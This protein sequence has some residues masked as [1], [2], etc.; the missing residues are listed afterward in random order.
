[1]TKRQQYA[2]TLAM[3]YESVDR[4]K[5]IRDQCVLLLGCGGQV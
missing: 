2:P 1:M 3:V 4:T 5:Q